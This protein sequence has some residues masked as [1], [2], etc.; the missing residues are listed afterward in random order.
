MTI[1]PDGDISITNHLNR[2][3]TV[4]L[5][6]DDDHSFSGIASIDFLYFLQAKEY[7]IQNIKCLQNIGKGKFCL[8]LQ[9]ILAKEIFLE[10]FKTF[11]I[12]NCNYTVEAAGNNTWEYPVDSIPVAVFG[13]PCEMENKHIVNKLLNYCDLVKCDR[14]TFKPFPTVESGVRIVYAKKIYK[15]IPSHIYVKGIHVSIKYEGQ[16]RGK[17]CYNCGQHGHLGR[18]CPKPGKRYSQGVTPKP[19]KPDSQNDFPALH[20]QTSPKIDIPPIVPSP[21]P[22]QSIDNSNSTLEKEED[23][24]IPKQIADPNILS[25]TDRSKECANVNIIPDD[26]HVPNPYSINQKSDINIS[27]PTDIAHICTG[28]QSTPLESLPDSSGL[29]TPISTRPLVDHNDLYADDSLNG[30]P[31]TDMTTTFFKTKRGPDLWIFNNSL[32][33]DKKHIKIRF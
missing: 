17:T 32:V 7:N 14:S 26:N 4:E 18:E 29:S 13:L 30:T 15:P 25:N 12:K 20:T 33:F 3:I 19:P 16:I 5:I 6:P 23:I 22:N 1:N 31:A 8:T 9:D 28:S 2:D 11:T 10:T 24:T 27:C 21:I